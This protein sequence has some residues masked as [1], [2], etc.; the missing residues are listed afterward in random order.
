MTVMNASEAATP[1]EQRPEI[2]SGSKRDSN[3]R[4]LRCRCSA[5][6]TELS[7]PHESGRMPVSPLYVDVVLGPSKV[8]SEIGFC[9]LVAIE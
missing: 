3:P 8:R 6:P 2:I 7:K 1:L 5:L 9:P 4:P